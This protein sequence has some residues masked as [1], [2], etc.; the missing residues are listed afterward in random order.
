MVRMVVEEWA[1]AVVVH[2]ARIKDTDRKMMNPQQ[3]LLE[4]M[5]IGIITEDGY[6]IC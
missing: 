2:T 1:A 3:K 6:G 5:N 4:K